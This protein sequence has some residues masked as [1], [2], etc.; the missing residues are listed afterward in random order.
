MRYRDNGFSPMTTEKTKTYAAT[1]IEPI[2]NI[3]YI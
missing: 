2:G 3:M 1:R